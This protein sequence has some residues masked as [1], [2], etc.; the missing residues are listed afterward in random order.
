[1]PSKKLL[2]FHHG[3]LGDVVASFTSLLLL[4]KEYSEIDMVCR[5]SIG[6]MAQHLKVIDRSFSLEN[7]IFLKLFGDECFDLN[8][9]L[10]TFL[11]SYDD[12]ILFSFSVELAENIKIAS[13][14]RVFQIPPRPE[15]SEKI[16]VGKS[17][18]SSLVNTKL[19][20]KETVSNFFDLYQNYS[21]SDSKEKKIYIHPGSGSQLKNWP[22]QYFFKLEKM[23]SYDGFNPVFILGPAE[24]SLAENF[25]KNGISINQVI[26]LYDLIELVN[27]L[28]TGEGFI[29]NDSGVAHLAAFIGLPTLVIFGP[30]DPL[31]WCP[32][33]KKVETIRSEFDCDPCF[34]SLNRGCKSMGCLAGLSPGQVRKKFHALKYQPARV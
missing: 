11:R 7:A 29:G 25:L 22:F 2:A 20:K 12:I 31:R 18:L 14:K 5:Q 16:N 1:M 26:R 4:R 34:E 10:T 6:C 3:A 23:L 8:D 15:P 9:K 32:M 30:T 17:L 19:L 21:S 24:D 33:G 13:C 27:T 28:K